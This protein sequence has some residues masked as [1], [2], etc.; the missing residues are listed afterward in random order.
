MWSKR[1][2]VIVR[3][4]SIFQHVLLFRVLD[5]H[6]KGRNV[7]QA[8]CCHCA[9]CFHFKISLL[10]INPLIHATASKV[11]CYYFACAAASTE[12]VPGVSH[13]LSP[14]TI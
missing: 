10:G 6:A 9:F 3:F 7:V 12:G 14:E 11:F 5:L 1:F 4:V 2:A 8:F 13:H